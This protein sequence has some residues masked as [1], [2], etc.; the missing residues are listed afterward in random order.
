MMLGGMVPCSCCMVRQS[1]AADRR[2][3]PVS[4][5]IILRG[6]CVLLQCGKLL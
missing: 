3:P 5:I 4:I 2:G 1:R 6:S